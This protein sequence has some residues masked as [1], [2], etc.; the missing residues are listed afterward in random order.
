MLL[1]RAQACAAARRVNSN[2]LLAFEKRIQED[3]RPAWN[4]QG[5]KPPLE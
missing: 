4:T 1:L 2:A 3:S 5:L